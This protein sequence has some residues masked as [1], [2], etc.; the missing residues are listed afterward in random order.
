M[1]YCQNLR[2][3]IGAA[4]RDSAQTRVLLR[5]LAALEQPLVQLP[6]EILILPRAPDWTPTSRATVF[7]HVE[8]LDCPS[9]RFGTTGCAY[10]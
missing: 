5:S 9:C 3:H 6:S 2:D 1:V 7:R 8:H 4:V 10:G